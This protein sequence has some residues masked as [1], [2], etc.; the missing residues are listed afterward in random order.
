MRTG[1]SLPTVLPPGNAVPGRSHHRGHNWPRS[2]LSTAICFVLGNH[3][4]HLD[5]VRSHGNLGEE[6]ALEG[7]RRQ[8]GIGTNVDEE[9]IV[10]S[11]AVPQPATRHVERHARHHHQIE[12]LWPDAPPSFRV[13]DRYLHASKT[14]EHQGGLWW[15]FCSSSPIQVG[16]AGPSRTS[17]SSSQG[18]R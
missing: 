8:R 10:V 12:L 18:K 16:S 17:T 14:V 13:V 11:S 4:V 7:Q 5:V 1:D 2:P 6:L 3:Q 15:H 9:S